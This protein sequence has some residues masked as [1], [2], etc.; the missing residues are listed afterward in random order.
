MQLLPQK[1]MRSSQKLYQPTILN[2][3]LQNKSEDTEIINITPPPVMHLMLDVANTLYNYIKWKL[4]KDSMK[5]AFLI[6][7]GSSC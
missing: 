2:I 1:R 4:D 5:W 3:L 7:T 6:N